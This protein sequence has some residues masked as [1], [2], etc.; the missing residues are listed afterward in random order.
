MSKSV[1]IR[2]FSISYGMVV[3]KVLNNIRKNPAWYHLMILFP[4]IRVLYWEQIKR[5]FQF[6]LCQKY[7]AYCP[8][9][10]PPCLSLVGRFSAGES[11]TTVAAK[12][13]QYPEAIR[14]K[15][16]DRAGNRPNYG[17]VLSF[18]RPIC[19]QGE[20]PSAVRS[21]SRQEGRHSQAGKINLIALNSGQSNR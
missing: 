5:W 11:S 8:W 19:R 14:E 18:P 21:I 2:K 10:I 16:N 13:G 4:E 1:K 12:S 7:D 6:P 3:K 20:F 17:L 9:T 15:R